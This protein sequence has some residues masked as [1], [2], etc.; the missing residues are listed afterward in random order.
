MNV[1]H[2]RSLRFSVSRR[3]CHAGVVGL[4]LALAGCAAPKVDLQPEAKQSVRRIAVIQTPE[5]DEYLMMPA[6][7]PAGAG[8]YLFGAIGGAILGGIE[9]NRMKSASKQFTD[10]VAPFKPN[11]H[12]TFQSRL[13]AGL[14]A[15]GYQVA[16][17][18]APPKKSDGK[19][20]DLSKV[21]GDFDGFLVA[22]LNGGYAMQGRQA[23]PR[24]VGS[25]ALQDRSS[26][27]KYFAQTYVY[28]PMKL[29]NANQI[30]AEP[31]HTF[32]SAEALHANGQLA[33]DALRTGAS[34]IADEVIAQF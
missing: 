30:A 17:V 1:Q 28:G 12:P 20:Y 15:K 25:V 3:A 19:D 31:Q 4:V 29:P 13:A 26:E 33:A 2:R 6:Q 18:P 22:T 10:A 24:L 32:A 23:V 9:A 34:K 14:K 7:N 5:P 11:V 27:P 16:L 8:L 21:Q